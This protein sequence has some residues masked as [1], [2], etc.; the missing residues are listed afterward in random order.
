VYNDGQR[1]IPINGSVSFWVVPWKL[2]LILLVIGAFVA[3]GI[4]SSLRRAGHFV[5]KARRGSDK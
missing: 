2:I 4:W 1:D 5:N 3:I